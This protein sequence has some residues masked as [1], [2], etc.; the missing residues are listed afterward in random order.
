MTQPN[1]FFEKAKEFMNNKQY[2]K[3]LE[4][5]DVCYRYD[6]VREKVLI[7]KISIFFE[8]KDW[9][10]AEICCLEYIKN[11]EDEYTKSDVQINLAKIY[12]L[13]NRIDDAIE[14]FDSINKT[15]VKDMNVFNMERLEISYWK[16]NNYFMINQFPGDKKEIQKEF[17]IIKNIAPGEPRIL[18]FL[19]KIS[20]FLHDYDYAKKL[21]EQYGVL[22][23]KDVLYKNAILFELKKWAESEISC[24]EYIKNPE[25]EYT[26]ADMQINLTKIYKLTNRID[27]T[28]ELFDSINKNFVK[29]IDA[30]NKERL[31]SSYCKYNDY[32]MVH[33]F[34]RD[35]KELYKEFQII[36]NIP[37][38]EPKLLFF[39]ARVSNFLHDYDYT[40]KLIEQYNV[41]AENDVF[42]KNAILN[43][44]EIAS[45]SVVLKSFPRGLWLL[46][47]SKCN[48]SCIMCHSN[49]MNFE[50]SENNMQKIS[51]Y[52][53]YLEHIVWWG[54]EP[55]ISPKFYK[56]LENALAY[57][58]IKH[59]II[60]NGQ[61]MPDNLAD[62]IVKNNIEVVL[63]IDSVEKDKYEKIRKG[64]SFEKLLKTI[65]ILSP[66]K[67]KSLLKINYVVMNMNKD[68]LDK[69][70]DFARKHQILKINFLPACVNN[71]EV[72]NFKISDDD[73]KNMDIEFSRVSEMEIFNSCDI[74]KNDDMKIDCKNN[75][76]CHA[77]WT[78]MTFSYKGTI[79]PD[80]LCNFFN[81][82]EFILDETNLLDYWNSQY[83]QEL[84]RFVLAKHACN[85]RCP[86]AN[87]TEIT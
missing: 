74:I 32:F 83:V 7:E 3:A 71:A 52:F 61:Y 54:G 48:I 75:V 25:D 78:Y 85:Y 45:G 5:F 87:V 80:N 81:G 57:K 51:T 79:F 39:L 11:P 49:E 26:K 38:G 63:S 66:L 19:I 84:R 69:V 82:K 13:T 41:F 76:F 77:P 50:M 67:E 46:L 73:A 65:E 21:F 15:F 27:D 31:D 28:I 10:Q 17:Q 22:A 18:F 56:L 40:K 68:E 4:Y 59:T 72:N 53:K 14:L 29:D 70:F 62:L 2:E 33:Q 43:E 6:Y 9:K 64:A 55:T 24:L 1:E 30:F 37:P 60:T 58:N 20:N 34:P 35:K 23:E 44:Y 86:Q 16:Y 42:Y 47:S 8:L 12:K 36:K